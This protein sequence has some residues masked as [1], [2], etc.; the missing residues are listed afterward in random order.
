VLRTAH[1]VKT[2]VS[3][4]QAMGFDFM[5]PAALRCC[6]IVHYQNSDPQSAHAFAANSMRHFAKYGATKVL[7]WCP[8]CNDHYDEVVSK[9][10]VVD[11][12]YEHVTAFIARHLDRIPFVRRVE[13]RV[14]MPY[15]SGYTQSDLDW[16]STRTILRAVP[17]SS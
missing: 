4:L 14:A 8:S 2:I 10:Q 3:V 9:E 6:G 13:K 16:Q 5:R 7:M 11:F 12:P 15:H 17:D 1:L